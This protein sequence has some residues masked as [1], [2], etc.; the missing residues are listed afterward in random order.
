MIALVVIL[1]LLVLAVVAIAI[2][3]WLFADIV[4]HAVEITRIEAEERMA[5]WRLQAISRHAQEEMRRIRDVHR[6]QSPWDRAS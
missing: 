6:T 1:L 2:W 5:L 3:V 4:D